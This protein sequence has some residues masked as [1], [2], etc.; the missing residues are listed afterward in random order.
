RGAPGRGRRPPRGGAPGTVVS[1]PV[2]GRGRMGGGGVPP[3]PKWRGSAAPSSTARSAPGCP[4][5]G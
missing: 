2:V 4:T 1:G 5:G 3:A